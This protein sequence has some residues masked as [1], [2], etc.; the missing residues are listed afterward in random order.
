VRNQDAVDVL[1]TRSAQRF[2]A[3]QH[4]FFA[5]SGVD[6]ESR[7][8]RFEQ[9]AIA[10]TTRGQNGYAERDSISPVLARQQLLRKMQRRMDDGKLLHARQHELADTA[11]S[12]F[13]SRAKMALT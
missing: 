1:G 11:T 5:E 3:P 2:E 13:Y 4:F 10:R 8:P 9:C 12:G 7:T 6:K